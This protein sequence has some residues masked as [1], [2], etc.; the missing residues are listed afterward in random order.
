M[1]SDAND[2]PSTDVLAAFGRP[3]ASLTLL[4]GGEG[5]TWQADRLILKPCANVRESTW[6][7]SVAAAVPESAD[8][9]VARPVRADD[10]SWIKYGWEAWHAVDGEPDERRVADVVQAG[11]A[12]HRSLAALPRPAFLEE[13]DN[14][15]TYGDRIAWDE[16]LLTGREVMADLLRPLG[17]A[18]RPV[19]VA[20]QVVHGDLLGNVLFAEGPAARDH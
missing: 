17:E 14:P 18:R 3:R 4:A 11:R 12:F 16:H 1:I 19:T 9:R 10:G 20:D 8:F 15:W 6:V 7:A 13:R 2:A 5:R